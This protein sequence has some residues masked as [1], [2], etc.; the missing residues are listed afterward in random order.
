[1]NTPTLCTKSPITWMNAAL[2]FIFSWLLWL[3][4]LVFNKGRL[5]GSEW[6]CPWLSP[7]WLCP[8]PPW[9]CPCWCKVRPIKMLKR[10]PTPD[11]INIIFASMS[12]SLSTSRCM[13]RYTRIPVTIQIISTDVKAPITSKVDQLKNKNDWLG[14]NSAIMTQSYLALQI[15][16]YCIL[17]RSE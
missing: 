14:P 7:P 8:P 4:L 6:L 15:F 17:N 16:W 2:T 9:L 12:N 3:S 10:T 11:V 5:S 1:M 13:A